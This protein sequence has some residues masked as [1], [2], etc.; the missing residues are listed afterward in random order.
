[1]LRV[2]SIRRYPVKSC[3]GHETPS[4]VVQPWG[5]AGDRRWML[6]GADGES[7][8]ARER[9]ELVLVTPE[10][11]ETG[12]LLH[13]P[14]AHPLPVRIPTGGPPLRVTVFGNP[15]PAAP[16]ATPA[17]AWFSA[18]LGTTATL[19][20]LD[21]PTQRRP[22]PDHSL[23][24]DRVTFAD[25][26][27][28]LL[29]TEESLA[30]LNRL[31]LTHP[32]STGQPLPMARFRPNVVV[33]GEPAWAEDRW[34]RL[35]IGVAVFRSVKGCPRCVLTTVDPDTGRRGKEPLRTL[36]R[37]RRWA[38][39]TWFGVNLIP[40]TPGAVIRVGDRVEVTER[41]DTSEPPPDP[42]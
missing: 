5:L 24:G 19:V 23:P 26:F 41:A 1:M 17:S 38:G 33:A 42:V 13:A 8:T 3:R 11:T 31:A 34:R 30:E 18:V 32:D 6:V 4:A 16:A 37:Y 15:L 36:A 25:G 28:L 20:Y 12:L 29:T 7:I 35:R 14:G 40:D 39:K 2:N 9:P 10:L 22:S 27:P 21:D